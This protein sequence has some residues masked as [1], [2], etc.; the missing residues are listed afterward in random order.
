MHCAVCLCVWETVHF[1]HFS[2]ALFR[3]DLPEVLGGAGGSSGWGRG[4]VYSK[5]NSPDFWTAGCVRSAPSTAM[6]SWLTLTRCLL[7][8]PP[9]HL[10]SL[11]LTAPPTQ[12]CSSLAKSEGRPVHARPPHMV[13]ISEQGEIFHF[14]PPNSSPPRTLSIS[15]KSSGSP[16][17]ELGAGRRCLRGNLVMSAH[18]PASRC[19][20]SFLLALLLWIAP[21][22]SCYRE[23]FFFFILETP[24][25][26]SLPLVSIQ[27][28]P[29][30][31]PHSA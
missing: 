19:F 31:P 21:C 12:R 8:P 3:R 15:L 16:G 29:H 11:P 22:E 6:W 2:T 26:C 9:P 30:T 17:R 24:L 14:F 28:F 10:P 13:S 4:L 23:I 27:V 7:P 5:Q 20:I 25:L 18:S 1:W